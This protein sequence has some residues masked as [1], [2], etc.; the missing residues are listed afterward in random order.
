MRL[1]RLS[2]AIM[3]ILAA[4]VSSEAQEWPRYGHD[5]ALTGRCPI[6]GAITDPH[7][8][9]SYSVAGREL[10]LEL[11]PGAGEQSVTLKADSAP[12]RHHPSSAPAGPR[13]L[14]IEG[15]GTLRPAVETFHE[16][17][18]KILP[19][20]PGYQ[21]VCWDQTWTDQAACHLQLFAYDRGFDQPYR[22]WE[23]TPPEA[24][25]F[26]P[27]NV[28]FDI[29]GDGVQEI[30]VA[31]HYRV[32]IFEGTTGRKETELRYHNS[33]PYGWF[34]L[35]D[36]D[37]DGQMELVTIGDFQSHVDVLDYDPRASGSG[38]A[39]RQVATRHRT[40]HRRAEEMA[41]GRSPPP[42][43]RDGRRAPRAD[44]ESV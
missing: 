12:N 14:D 28:V 43:R 35:A 16:R 13:Q 30:C 27:L 29:D 40:E 31:A 2:T 1:R 34:G 23:S 8:A 5:G 19:G 26:N 11:E 3:W 22:V 42:G 17:W 20:V 44:S 38:T 37:A 39:E 25:I 6:P 24:T 21:R 7:V 36:V 32:M 4:A 33:R 18:A 9:W 15:R 41:A 10:L